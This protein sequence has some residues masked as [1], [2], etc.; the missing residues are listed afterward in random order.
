MRGLAVL[1]SVMSFTVVA[2]GTAKPVGEM[3]IDRPP[4]ERTRAEALTLEEAGF[5]ASGALIEIYG[6]DADPV[7]VRVEGSSDELGGQ[8]MWRLDL[9]VDVTV[10]G[11]RA[12]HRW[13]M[14]IGTS[15]DEDATVLRAV[16][17]KG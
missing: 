13:Q 9:R 4:A 8:T 7:P 2:C 1:V 12:E 11:E 5:I 14:W 16:R 6:L 10:D 3:V 17:V 15:D